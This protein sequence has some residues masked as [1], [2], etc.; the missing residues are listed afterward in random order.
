MY[1]VAHISG[2]FDFLMNETFLSAFSSDAFGSLSRSTILG[3]I[4][5]IFFV[6]CIISV[7]LSITVA[8]IE[9]SKLDMLGRVIKND[10]GPPKRGILYGLKERIGPG[11]N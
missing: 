3:T 7:I 10:R 9:L 2:F 6:I 1:T 8:I 4:P 5:N 11:R